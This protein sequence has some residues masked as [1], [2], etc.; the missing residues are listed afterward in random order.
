MYLKT[1][2]SRENI[3]LGDKIAKKGMKGV[4][5]SKTQRIEGTAQKGEW[6]ER[7]FGKRD[8]GRESNETGE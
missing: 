5:T 7:K 2:V 3:E 8:G 1:K 6:E 4:T